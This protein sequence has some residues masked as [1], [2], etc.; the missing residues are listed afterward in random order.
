[1]ITF[2]RELISEPEDD[3]TVARLASTYRSP[4]SFDDYDKTPSSSPFNMAGN[5]SVDRKK[6]EASVGE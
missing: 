1:M 4:L 3:D 6:R 5:H 2:E